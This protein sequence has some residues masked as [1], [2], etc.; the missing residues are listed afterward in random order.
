MKPDDG[1]RSRTTPPAPPTACIECHRMFMA[2]SACRGM[3]DAVR[4]LLRLSTATPSSPI[5]ETSI[6][7]PHSDKVGMP[8][9]LPGSA[10]TGELACEEL[11]PG[12]V[13][14]GAS[15]VAVFSNG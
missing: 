7:T 2:R 8:T 4:Q 15:T 6:S 11:L 13:S 14:P 5:N 9:A 10:P 12:F 1:G 3:A